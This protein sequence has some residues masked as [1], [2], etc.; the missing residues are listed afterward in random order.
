MKLY[1][2]IDGGAST[3][4]GVL[5]NEN[6][7]T[8]NKIIINKGTNLKEF[9]NQAP[10][11]LIALIIDL[12][13]ELELSIKDISAFGFGLAAVSFD[14]GRESLFKE[15]DRNGISNRSLLIND[16][17]AAYKIV[18]PDNVGI[19]VTVGTGII[20]IAKNLD[21]TFV[22]S[23]G[24]GHENDL[25]SGYWIGKETFLKLALNEAIID[26]DKDLLEI[27]N[28]ILDKFNYDSFKE[29]LEYITESEDSLTLKASIAKD[30]LLVSN[31]NKVAMKIVQQGTY[32][33]SEYILQIIDSLD[34]KPS[35]ELIL[36]GNGS[37]INSAIYRKS[38][39]DALL[40]DYQNISWVF[41]NLSASYGAAILA[42]LSKDNITITLKKILNGDYLVSA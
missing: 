39:S 18:C 21:G 27:K 23:A 34:Y 32:N 8:L 28:I 12:C 6:G 2:G 24:K 26:F 40:F 5:I 15:L 11:L 10:K 20:C 1:I 13:T 33:L 16:A 38:L 31:K 7:E 41:S 35:S 22:K 42:A 19:L 3:T 37:I 25:G 14:R 36:F 29:T 9:E 4:R 30:I 17:E